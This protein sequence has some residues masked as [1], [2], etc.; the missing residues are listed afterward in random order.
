LRENRRRFPHSGYEFSLIQQIF[1]GQQKQNF[2]VGA[3]KAAG[4]VQHGCVRFL[5]LAMPIMRRSRSLMP[6]RRAKASGK[7]RNPH[8]AADY[9]AERT[10][11]LAALARYDGCQDL[12]YILDLATMEAENVGGL[13]KAS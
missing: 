5:T 7:R 9:I 8:P 12:A 3:A 2:C 10:R 4:V 11:Q 13:P 6:A 1:I